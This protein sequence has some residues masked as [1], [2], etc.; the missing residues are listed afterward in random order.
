MFVKSGAFLALVG[1]GLIQY[2]AADADPTPLIQASING[3]IAALALI[4][5]TITYVWR[6]IGFEE[7]KN[8]REILLST[9]T[10]V[11]QHESQLEQLFSSLKDTVRT[12]LKTLCDE[13]ESI[14]KTISKAVSELLALAKRS[15]ESEDVTELPRIKSAVET[16][17]NELVNRRQALRRELDSLYPLSGEFYRLDIQIIKHWGVS[18]SKP[19]L[20]AWTRARLTIGLRPTLKA[21]KGISVTIATL[22]RLHEDPRVVALSPRPLSDGANPDWVARRKRLEELRVNNAQTETTLRKLINDIGEYTDG[23][24]AT[25]F[26]LFATIAIGALILLAKA[27]SF[28][29]LPLHVPLVEQTLLFHPAS[30]AYFFTFFYSILGITKIVWRFIE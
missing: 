21:A 11:M 16:Q 3:M 14:D 8:R 20:E 29:V 13:I 12:K 23:M 26:S 28:V 27:V 18:K 30:F 15:K 17:I 5:T 19:F 2:F 4:F 10:Q 24:K 1:A 7:R 6:A 22:S 9:A 25:V